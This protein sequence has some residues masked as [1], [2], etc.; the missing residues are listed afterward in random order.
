MQGQRR[1]LHDLQQ[2]KVVMGHKTDTLAQKSRYAFYVLTTLLGCYM[3]VSI[4]LPSQIIFV[5]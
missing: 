1:R 3:I 4:L 5:T 2:F